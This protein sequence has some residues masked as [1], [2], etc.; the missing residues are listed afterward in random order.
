MYKYVSG[1]QLQ[2]KQNAEYG[3]RQTNA[4]HA[5][6]KAITDNSYHLFIRVIS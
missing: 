4:S 2:Y 3:L 5:A 1:I 6:G